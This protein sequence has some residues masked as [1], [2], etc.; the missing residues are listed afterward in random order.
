MSRFP[1]LVSPF[2]RSVISPFGLFLAFMFPAIACG[3][4]HGGNQMT[5]PQAPNITTEPSN[6]STRVG[7]T[8]TF[9]V[10]AS[11]SA[12]LSYQWSKNGAAISE[13]TGSSYITP[14]AVL[15][16]NGATFAVTVSNS[17][18]SV[19]SN[20]A[21]L[22]VGPRAPQMGDWRFQGVDLPG[23]DSL[24]A[25]FN[26]L[27][28]QT[29]TYTNQIGTPLMIGAAPGICYPGIADDCS[30]NIAAYS[31]PTGV[32]GMKTVFQTDAFTNLESDLDA[33]N[34]P[35][36][37]ITG[38]DLEA[39]NQCFAV[40]SLQTSQAGGFTFVR[41]WVAPSDVQAV[42]T[43]LGQESR[44]ITALSFNA[45]QVYVLSYSWQSDTTTIYEVTVVS[46]TGDTFVTQAMNLAAQ[47]YIVTAMGG[48]PTDGLLLVGTRVQ[49]D[50]IARPVDYVDYQGLHGSLPANIQT[51]SRDIFASNPNSEIWINEQ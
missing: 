22:A 28:A 50:T 48:D 19:G 15:A 38:L 34:N 14:V 18:G 24:S 7:Q 17:V 3:S 20:A 31:V 12:P 23:P 21:S 6:Q 37:V 29:E 46:A 39:A 32:S 26:I 2:S 51:L 49:G 9:S 1:S 11:G 10:V 16:D 40:S 35:N 41:Q 25:A 5:A 43:Q 4:G 44:V 30:W 36:I 33:L 27:V 8:A 45:G 42:A 13:A 47:G